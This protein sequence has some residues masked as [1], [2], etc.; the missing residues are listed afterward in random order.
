[1]VTGEYFCHRLVD[2]IYV[3]ELFL[4]HTKRKSQRGQVESNLKHWHILDPNFTVVA[5]P[6]K[7]YIILISRKQ[8]IHDNFVSATVTANEYFILFYY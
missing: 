8:T 1:M 6:L 3:I 5:V 4:F 2:Y 7:Y